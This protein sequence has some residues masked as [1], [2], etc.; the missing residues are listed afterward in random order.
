MDTRIAIHE[1]SRSVGISSHNVIRRL[2]HRDTYRD[3]LVTIRDTYHWSRYVIR[4]AILR[5]RYNIYAYRRPKYRDASMH[6]YATSIRPYSLL[7]MRCRHRSVK[8]MRALL[9]RK[10]YRPH[11]AYYEISNKNNF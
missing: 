2:W 1:F 10:Q 3:T 8:T 5:S 11:N 9:S 4:I 7:Y 6:R